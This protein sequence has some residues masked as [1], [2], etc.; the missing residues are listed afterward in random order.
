MPT[1]RTSNDIGFVPLT[2][3]PVPP[4]REAKGCP[5]EPCPLPAFE[6]LQIEDIPAHISE[7]A[8]L[9][10]LILLANLYR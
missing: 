7:H 1:N 4:T 6:S 2:Q 3:Y 5:L 9:I 10:Q 8:P